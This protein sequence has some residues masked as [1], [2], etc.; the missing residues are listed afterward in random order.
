MT[1]LLSIITA[2]LLMT[3]STA[4]SQGVD[5]EPWELS[6]PFFEGEA[7]SHSIIGGYGDWCDL[8]EGLHPGLDFGAEISDI[9]LLPTDDTREVIYL[10]GNSEDG[11]CMVFG[12]NSS[13][14][15]GWGITHL[16]IDEPDFWPFEPGSVIDNH[17]PLSKCK[18]VSAEVGL[19]MHLQWVDASPIPLPPG[20]YNPFNYFEDVLTGYDEVQFNS[21]KWEEYLS[22]PRN[23][24]IWFIPD[25]NDGAETYSQFPSGVD[26]SVFQNII[27]GAVDIAVAPF[28][29]FQGLS[30]RDSAGVYSVSYEILLQDPIT[31]EYLPAVPGAGNFEER[32]LME[33]RDELPYHLSPVISPEYRAIYSDGLRSN[34]SS[35]WIDPNWW[36]YMN[37][38]IVTNSGALDPMNWTTGWDNVWVDSY[39]NDWTTGICQGA[40][41]TNLQLSPN[42]GD[43]QTN[44]DA[45]FPDGRYAVEVTAVSHG[46]RSTGTMTL[47]MD[48]LSL[49]DPQTEGVVVDN[50]L[51]HIVGVAAYAW[52]PVTRSC[53]LIYE[54]YWE[55]IVSDGAMQGESEYLEHLRDNLQTLQSEDI[56]NSIPSS[57]M[58]DLTESSN[59]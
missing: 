54:G 46:S 39:L 51:P 5:T 24:G 38:Y 4:E 57:C 21:V 29:A 17:Q 2:T 31:L 25:K 14:T 34:S 30:D 27:S 19:H 44:A 48:D 37:A 28:S 41:D 10:G 9:V 56:S 26:P 42:T 43:A 20:L 32:F 15:E 7:A 45:F 33:M 23:R 50:F 52:D 6:W 16:D 35:L 8:A 40:W 11:F 13:S 1:I 12:E 18:S 3:L 53:D 59:Q 47:P 58:I 22:P 49:P 36:Y 55:D